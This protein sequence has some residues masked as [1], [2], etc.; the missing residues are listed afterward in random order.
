[1]STTDQLIIAF[2]DFLLGPWGKISLGVLFVVLIIW[3]MGATRKHAYHYAMKGAGFG[4]TSAIVT[5]IV[6]IGAFAYL[7]I[8]RQMFLSII[9]GKRPI[10]DLPILAT[11]TLNRFQFVL[12]AST[13]E[14]KTPTSKEILSLIEK[15]P[16]SE[17]IKLQV[18]TCQQVFK[19]LPR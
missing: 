16:A 11:S 5:A 18:Q 14:E 1:V 6:L 4:A 3:G 13:T 2:Y 9:T 10:S 8:D 15:L 17:K 12:G 19:G 7:V